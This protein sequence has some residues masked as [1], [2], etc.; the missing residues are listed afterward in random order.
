MNKP[1]DFSQRSFNSDL[2]A[3]VTELFH[4]DHYDSNQPHVE[5]ENR[6]GD[7]ILLNTK[8][9]PDL[10]GLEDRKAVYITFSVL[11]GS[12]VVGIDDYTPRPWHENIE[13]IGVEY[14][15]MLGHVVDDTYPINI[16]PIVVHLLSVLVPNDRRYFIPTK[17]LGAPP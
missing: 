14:C 13:K 3:I 10:P 2:T 11:I 1:F 16:R 8:P 12:H 5:F 9:H 4:F 7:R 15:W 6:D 17:L